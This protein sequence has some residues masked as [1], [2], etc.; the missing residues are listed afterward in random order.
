MLTVDGIPAHPLVV[1][2]VV[3]LLPLAAVA[4]LLV[5]ARPVW[6][7]HLGVWV[8]LLAAAG[9][10]AIP[11]ATTTGEQLK[12]SLGGGGPLIEIHEERAETLLI[13]ALVYLALLAA[14]VL[15]GRRADAAVDGPGA[16]HA[17]RSNVG[18]LH[19][20]TVITGV[21]AALAGLAVT[22]LV[23]W[24]GHAGSAAVWQS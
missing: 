24:I 21:L 14:T 4:T 12:Q 3:V 5:V 16:A 17:T 18:S 1:H 20:I 10:F 22:G 15:V 7:R 8:L 9:V 11:V 23:V 6:R 19:R 13:P 2:A